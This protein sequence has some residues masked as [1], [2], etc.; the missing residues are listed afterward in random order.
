MNRDDLVILTRQTASRHGL[1][2]DLV[3]GMVER[4]SSWF[5]WTIRYE[6]AFMSHYIAPL[7]TLGKFSAS[8]AYA[9]SFS[10]GLMQVMGD[11]ARENGFTGTFLAQLC[12]PQIGLEIGCAVFAKHLAK[13]AYNA[14]AALEAWNGGGNPNYAQEVLTLAEHFRLLFAQA[15]V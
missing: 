5:P 11:V 2:P 15:K 3:C 10:W 7:Y 12:D 1:D 9:R 4:E 14:A 8:E 13:S 6:P